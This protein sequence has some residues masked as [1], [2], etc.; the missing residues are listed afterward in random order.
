MALINL[1]D[2]QIEEREHAAAL[3]SYRRSAAIFEARL[4]KDHLFVSYALRG[5]GSCLVKLRRTGEAIPLLERASRIRTASGSPPVVITELRTG[6]SEPLVLDPRTRARELAEVKLAAA[7][8]EQTG[9][10]VIAAEV[11]SWLSKHR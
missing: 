2:L 7:K 5:V 4:G 10:A 3:E 1:G 6:L 11:R 8:Y 9:D